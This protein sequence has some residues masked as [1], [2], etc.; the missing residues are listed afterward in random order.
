MAKKKALLFLFLLCF[1]VL[2]LDNP[3][4]RHIRAQETSYPLTYRGANFIDI[5]YGNRT[6]K[7][8]SASQAVWNG[9]HWVDYIFTNN[10]ATDNFV[11]VQ[12]GLVAADFYKGK[13]VYYSPD[14]SMLA[15]QREN[16]IVYKWNVAQ[17]E[18]KPICASLEPYFSSASFYEADDYVN[19]S[20]T[21]MT[22]AGNLTVQYHFR[23]SLKHT[24]I[25]TPSNDG[26]YAV[27]QA[28]N[29]TQYDNVKLENATI[30]KRTDNAVIGKSDA[31]TV[32]FFDETQPF[33]IMENQYSAEDLLHKIIFATGTVIYQGISVTDAVAWI[34]YNS[35][36]SMLASGESLVIDPTTTTFSPPNKDTYICDGDGGST[37]YGSNVYIS[38]RSRTPENYRLLIEFNI[39]EIAVG[40]IITSAE[41]RLKRYVGFTS[42]RTY[43]FR[44][45]T[46]SWSEAA[47]TWSTQ[48]AITETNG[49]DYDSPNVNGWYNNSVT[50]MVQDARDAGTICGIRIKDS[51]ESGS[52]PYETNFCSKEYNGD[53]PQLQV[54]YIPPIPSIGEFEASS[55]VYADL[56]FFLNCSVQD[57]DGKTTIINATIEISQSIILKHDIATNTFSEYQDTN[58]YCTLDV[59]NSLRA[60]VNSSAYKLSWKIK[61][62]RFF[63]KGLVSIVEA[64][65]K[66][67]DEDGNS[68]TG[69]YSNLF[70]LTNSAPT[71]S[72]FQAPSTVNT[73]EYFFLNCT[74]NDGDGKTTFDYVTLHITSPV[75]LKWINST[76]T[77]SIQSDPNGFCSLNASDSVCT[78]V[79]DTAYQ[80]SWSIML[81]FEY[82]EGYVSV[83]V[84][85]TKVFDDVG[86]SGTGSYSNLFTVVT[87][88]KCTFHG[89]FY[90][91]GLRAPALNIT[92]TR[93]LTGDTTY[94]LNGTLTLGFNSSNT[95]YCNVIWS[96]ELN[97]TTFVRYHAIKETGNIY[98]FISE[99]PTYV[100]D[101]QLQDYIGLTSSDYL[102]SLI[103]VNQTEFLVER[104]PITTNTLPFALKF[105]GVYIFRVT[106]EDYGTYVFG[107]VSPGQTSLIPLVLNPI[108]FPREILVVYKYVR[109]D[110]YREEIETSPYSQI[111]FKYND[112]LGDTLSLKVSLLY[113]NR[114]VFYTNTY[115][116]T[117][118][119]QLT[120]PCDNTTNYIVKAE[121]NHL[122][123]GSWGWSKPIPI[124]GTGKSPFDL[125]I[126]GDLPIPGTSIVALGIILIIAGAFSTVTSELGI[127][128]AALV[129]CFFVFIKWLP[130]PPES[131]LVFMSL[132]IIYAVVRS[133]QKARW[134]T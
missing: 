50:A 39:S 11:R 132:A 51:A 44:R 46:G 123:L 55:N 18:W 30:I 71:I 61:L 33:G 103:Q 115:Y 125:E 120:M 3:S 85:G 74:I 60:D 7:W 14:L 80:I 58:G 108:D 13:V 42:A 45:I 90:E 97:G 23:E 47:V 77:F 104:K 114:T 111:I 105:G 1:L 69:S 27:V 96:Y 95:E 56:Y 64:N 122:R 107:V 102:E 21:W 68:G 76:N 40:S 2:L 6:H 65:T 34:F 48:P 4:L 110:A 38:V 63:P 94:E 129:T 52:P 78:S 31:L 89:P 130:I 9:T 54:I 16:W 116:Y 36:L 37:N 101:I 88:Y 35:T 81:S 19:V 87:K 70:T 73:T 131:T 117:D 112:T 92:V 134:Q 83:L 75:I 29:G 32:L 106:T 124:F 82:P 93:G 10:Y 100:Y 66:V 8:L 12:S 53:D 98:I 43:Q 113:R 59:E 28:W 26:K 17:S 20:G 79:N 86:A 119:L 15:V 84:E 41:I 49:V 22:A 118:T 99:A 57:P 62:S 127:F 67:Y 5:D 72:S 109:F 133:R 25:W 24:V 126:F 91:N 121:L 128:L